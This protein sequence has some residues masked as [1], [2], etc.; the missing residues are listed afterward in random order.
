MKKRELYII[1]TPFFNPKYFV[2]QYKL[3]IIR[4]TNKQKH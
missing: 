1:A 4:K 3:S 2:I